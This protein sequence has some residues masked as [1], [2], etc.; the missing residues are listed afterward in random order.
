MPP[1]LPSKRPADIQHIRKNSQLR[2]SPHN[3]SSPFHSGLFC[4]RGSAQNRANCFFFHFFFH[5][6]LLSRKPKQRNKTTT[7]HALP[8]FFLSSFSKQRPEKNRR[9]DYSK[10]NFGTLSRKWDELKSI[11]QSILK[12][13]SPIRSRCDLIEIVKATGRNERFFRN[14]RIDGNRDGNGSSV[15]ILATL[16]I[17]RAES[18]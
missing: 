7:V 18:G 10:P 14:L 13:L 6:R 1:Q 15:T 9:S 3:V 2:P 12:I 4:W 5:P 17:L 11:G 16:G 8:R